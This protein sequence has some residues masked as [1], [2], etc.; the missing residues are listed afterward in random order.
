MSNIFLSYAHED[1]A[2][3]RQL[4]AALETH[5]WTVFWDRTIP[6]GKTWHEIID[7]ALRDARCVIVAWS[8]D[9]IKSRWVREEA[10]EGNERGILVPVLFDNV[11]PPLGYRQIQAA[12]LADWDGDTEADAFLNLLHAVTHI[13]GPISSPVSTSEQPS[14]VPTE[15]EVKNTAAEEPKSQ[16]EP[17]KPKPVFTTDNLQTAKPTPW[18]TITRLRKLWPA[19]VLLLLLGM[20]ASWLLY[21]KQMPATAP[22][23][24]EAPAMTLTPTKSKP[25][26]DA[27][28][29]KE[30]VERGG[31]KGPDMIDIPAGS[32]QMGSNEGDRDEKPVHTVSLKAFRMGR[33][34]VTFE[35]YDR[36]ATATGRTLPG[37]EGWGR[38]RRPVINVSWDDAA[39]YAD[40][41]SEQTGQRFRLPT[42]AEWEYAARAGT[43]AVRPWS[44][45]LEA[46]CGYANVFDQNNSGEIKKRYEITWDPFPCQ[47]PYAYTAPV[48]SFRKNG[49]GLYDAMGNVWEWVQDCYHENY[50]GA[51]P[52][53]TAWEP[54]KPK[55]CRLRVIRGGSWFDGPGTLRSA[56]RWF[57]P[58]YRDDFIGF[59]LAQDS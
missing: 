28:R 36:F 40:W 10:E 6:P 23:K 43:Q 21:V 3:A 44:G 8:T 46:A 7:G 34:E 58:V 1:L 14:P 20:A 5:G 29:V 42:E 41:L 31:I 4:A 9:S 45:G 2:R 38:G 48:G 32:F 18:G 59:R 11:R 16:R 49:F 57:D 52:D 13:V 33:T 25:A 53:G 26:E 35:E 50:A 12:D 22:Q 51:P 55:D 15:T 17:Q 27:T 39:A 19:A 30:P 54:R 37:D 47:D 24:P 56:A